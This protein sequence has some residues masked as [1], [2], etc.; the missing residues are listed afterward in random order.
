MRSE[1]FSNFA[2]RVLIIVGSCYTAWTIF[3]NVVQYIA[4]PTNLHITTGK[5]G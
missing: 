4:H 1:T 2:F 3:Q 5:D